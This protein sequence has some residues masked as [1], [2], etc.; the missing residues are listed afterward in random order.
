MSASAHL[1]GGPRTQNHFQCVCCRTRTTGGQRRACGECGGLL[2][3]P[4]DSSESNSDLVMAGRYRV[5]GRLA[6]TKM[7]DLFRVF[8]P[9]TGRLAVL[10]TINRLR[11][12]V[13]V[14]VQRF[15]CEA[16]AHFKFQHPCI[17]KVF[18]VGY[19]SDN[20]PYIVME[21]VDGLPLSQYLECRGPM[22]EAE[23][24]Q[25]G[26]QMCDALSHVHE[27]GFVHCD[28]K[29]QNIMV[30]HSSDRSLSAKLIDFG[31]SLDHSRAS[32]RRGDFLGTLGFMSPEQI[33]GDE[34]GPGADIYALGC[35][36]YTLLTGAEPFGGN[37]YRVVA[38]HL[39]AAVPQLRTRR[40][41]L[42]ACVEVAI[43]RAMAKDPRDRFAS[44]WD[45]RAAL[46]TALG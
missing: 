26:L 31:V 22:G 27:G 20:S 30:V 43:H 33:H 12:A 35:T 25:I 7:S 42:S 41:G 4:L 17:A 19:L 36:L 29:P 28:V 6:R 24:L 1:L 23:V 40:P 38:A 37:G 39:L 13:S 9:Q 10:K 32:V 21:L 45:F 8:D 11:A 44:M 15:W 2:I 34:V 3:R 14:D 18:D 46:G 16:R 5:L